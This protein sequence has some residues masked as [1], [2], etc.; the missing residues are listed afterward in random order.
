[1]YGINSGI[2]TNNG[3]IETGASSQGIYAQNTGTVTNNN[4]IKSTGNNVI[5]I[6]AEGNMDVTNATGAEI[7][8][9]GNDSIGIFSKYAA[10]STAV[11]TNSG[12]INIGDSTNIVNPG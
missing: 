9:S 7:N 10:S 6:Y 2:I 4:T 11:L 8:L 1:M 12:A 3:I 5:G